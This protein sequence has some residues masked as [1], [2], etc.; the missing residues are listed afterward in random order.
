MEESKYIVSFPCETCKL[1]LVCAH[2]GY[3]V[4]LADYLEAPV[5]EYISKDNF[6]AG[7]VKVKVACTFYDP[8]TSAVL[9]TP[10]DL[11]GQP[12]YCC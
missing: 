6:L 8:T 5:R 12:N 11:T 10:W 1:A 7:V 4:L 3:M 2:R 9:N